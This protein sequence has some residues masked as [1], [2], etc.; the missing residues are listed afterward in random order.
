MRKDG[1][2][3]RIYGEVGEREDRENGKRI[4]KREGGRERE[5]ER[6]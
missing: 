4:R 2:E 6:I 1:E 3:E 5:E